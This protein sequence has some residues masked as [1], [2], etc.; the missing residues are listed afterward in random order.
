MGAM[1][2]AGETI[3]PARGEVARYH[4][5]KYGVFHRMHDDFLAYRRAMQ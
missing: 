1:N 4:D 5:A 2:G 3:A